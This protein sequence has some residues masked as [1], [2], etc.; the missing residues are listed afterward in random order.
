MTNRM[1]PFG[2]LAAIII[3][4]LGALTLGGAFDS[5]AA[6]G[7]GEGAD[8]A[9]LCVEGFEDC[10]DMIVNTDDGGDEGEGDAPPANDL[11]DASSTCLVGTADCNDTPGDDDPDL[12]L[13][14]D[15]DDPDGQALAIEAA[16]AQ[17]EVMGGPPSSEVDV[18]GVESVTWSDACLGIETPGIACAQV[19]TPGYIVVLDTGI[20]AYTFHTDANGHAVLAEPAQ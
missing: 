2:S 5:D 11:G 17:L 13:S 16:F 18:S 19:I 10:Q 12:P 8:T 14:D 6:P 3:V 7:D 9:A 1:L 4:V 15:G 20:L